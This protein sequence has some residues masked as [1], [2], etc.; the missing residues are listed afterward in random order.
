MYN[1]PQEV[2]GTIANSLVLNGWDITQTL[3]W[4]RTPNPQW[5]NKSPNDI[6]KE[7]QDDVVI[8]YLKHQGISIHAYL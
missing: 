8:R 2:M 4:M 6:I 5:D 7:G 3:I 1:N